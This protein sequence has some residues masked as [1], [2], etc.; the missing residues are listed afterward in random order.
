MLSG[1]KEGQE[2]M[3]KSDPDSAIFMEDSADDVKRKIRQAYC[4]MGVVDGNPCLDWT[5]HI[6]FG[7]FPE[8]VAVTRT[9]ENGGDKCV[10]RGQL[11]WRVGEPPLWHWLLF[12]R[13]PPSLRFLRLC[14][15]RVVAAGSLRATRSS[16]PT[17]S[18][19]RCTRAISRPCSPSTST[20]ASEVLDYASPSACRG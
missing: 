19:A 6:V 4:P 1:L 14:F 10:S 12:F 16:R 13:G 20:R 2:K 18:R 3:S 5:K 8:G 7:K 9:P 11:R 15:S 17:L